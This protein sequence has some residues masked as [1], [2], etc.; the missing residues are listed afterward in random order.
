M[1]VTASLARE[2]GVRT[3]CRALNVPRCGFYRWQR[4]S[5]LA[6]GRW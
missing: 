4:P 3:A 2:V 5:G 1:T 6:V